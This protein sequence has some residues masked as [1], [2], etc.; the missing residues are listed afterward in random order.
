MNAGGRDRTRDVSR[1]GAALCSVALV[2]V[3]VP[4]A[5]HAES[6]SIESSSDVRVEA[7]DN[8]SL[9]PRSPGTVKTLALSTTVGASRRAENSATLLGATVT[10]LQQWGRGANDR[11]DGRIGVT[12]SFNDALNTVTASVQYAQDFNNTVQNADVTVNPGERRTATASVG[13]GRP[14]TER[15]SANAQVSFSQTAYAQQ[16]SAGVAPANDFRNASASAGLSYALTEIDTVSV[17]VS[18]SDYRAAGGGNQSST[19]EVSVS[20]SRVLS[21]R[22]SASLQLG[23]YQTDSSSP[24]IRFACPAAPV[25]CQLGLVQLILIRDRVQSSGT[26]LSYGASYRY[27]LGE[28]SSLSFSLGS[29]QSPSGAEGVVQ[30]KSLSL[31]LGHSFS[32]TMNGALS[33][34]MSRSTSQSTVLNQRSQRKTVAVSLSRQLSRDFSLLSNYQ[35]TEGNSGGGSGTAHSNSIGVALK[36]DWP[37]F[38]ASR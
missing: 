11:I 5:A 6:Y 13:W 14:L 37:T 38:Q 28:T 35:W 12:Q 33:F 16:T 15:L 24:R 20:A 8:V 25:L 23:V 18:H 3:G 21:N 2:W 1:R 29:Q 26:G 7:N 22:S 31:S 32:E 4:G 27:Q 36:Y 34:A 10:A 9:Q 19:N 30:N 17:Q